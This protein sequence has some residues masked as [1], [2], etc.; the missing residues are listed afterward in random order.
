MK[1][2]IGLASAAKLA[3]AN[4]WNLAST[5]SH[6]FHRKA[7]RY[8]LYEELKI[9]YINSEQNW[10][11]Q[12]VP[13]LID[14]PENSCTNLPWLNKSPYAQNFAYN[15]TKWYG[16]LIYFTLSKY[17]RW[18][19]VSFIILPIIIFLFLASKFHLTQNTLKPLRNPPPYNS[20]LLIVY[21]D[22][23]NIPECSISVFGFC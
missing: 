12:F 11:I 21:A 5:M 9:M 1:C 8:I 22:G 3:D 23:L 4:S 15:V 20:Y 13:G 16:N 19:P 7:I 18:A 14:Q 2:F 10:S 6:S 17:N